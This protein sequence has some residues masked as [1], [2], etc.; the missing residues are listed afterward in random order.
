MKIQLNYRFVNANLGLGRL[1]TF[2]SVV[3]IQNYF[4]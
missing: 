4:F 1:E 3:G 2:N